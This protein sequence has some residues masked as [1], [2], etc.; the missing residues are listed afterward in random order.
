MSVVVYQCDTCKR[1]THRKQNRFGLDVIS[2]CVITNGCR[3]KLILNAVKPSYAIGHS[4]APVIGLSDWTPRKVLFTHKQDFLKKKWE[5]RHNLNNQPSVSA[6]IYKNDQLV[7]VEPET[8][9][10]V[11]NDS[12]VVTFPTAATGIAQ[13][14]ARSASDGQN[15][16][17][18]I[19]KTAEVFDA[20]TFSTGRSFML[21]CGPDVGELTI[22]TR[23]A[24]IATSGFAPTQS[25]TMNVHFLSPTDLTELTSIP[26]ELTFRDVNNTPV[27]TISSPWAT[28]RYVTISGHK[29]L[30]RSANIHV[31]GG[32]GQT[33]T[34]RGVPQGAACSFSVGAATITAINAPVASYS[35][36]VKSVNGV[37]FIRQ[38][39]Q[40]AV[41]HGTDGA[42]LIETT[43]TSPVDGWIESSP[44][45]GQAVVSGGPLFTIRPV[46]ALKNAEVYVLGADAPYLGVDRIYDQA[47]DLV[48]ITADNATASTAYIGLDITANTALR[49]DIFP[50]IMLL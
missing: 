3:G 40:I 7:R 46:R 28:A 12:L 8:V 4:T 36:T 17:T 22:A 25:I 6:Y 11:S 15:I 16:T 34:D 32:I 48:D 2:H 44:T 50:S 18:L 42:T 33:L 24:T 41:I 14:Q 30:V 10:Y 43:I 5:I 27:D 35:R 9:E 38:G 13:C 1:E 31:G 20:T 26:V 23:V 21:T 37:R 19:P 47:V 39:E 45:V 49:K 29:Y